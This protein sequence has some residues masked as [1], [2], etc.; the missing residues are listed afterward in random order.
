MQDFLLRFGSIGKQIFDKVDHETLATCRF[1]N[2]S[3][4]I[5]IDQQKLPEIRKNPKINF[6]GRT[7]LHQAAENG[8]LNSCQNIL[9]YLVEKNPKDN[10]GVTPMHIA[11]ENGHLEICQ[12]FLNNVNDKD[13]K[14]KDGNTPF[15]MAVE[16]GRLS[17]YQLF[18]KDS[19]EKNPIEEFGNTPFH[20]GSLF[21]GGFFQISSSSRGF[22]STFNLM[23]KT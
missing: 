6:S 14:D 5:F 2:L 1:V 19:D 13:P 10:N 22:G 18:V 4:K 16:N 11:A 15:H 21:S 12:L 23:G 20:K 7:Q 3:W 17:I 9:A 8:D